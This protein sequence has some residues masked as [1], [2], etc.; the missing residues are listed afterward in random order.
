MACSVES[1]LQL[2]FGFMPKCEPVSLAAEGTMSYDQK[3]NMTYRDEPIED[4]FVHATKSQINY[5]QILATD[6]E[7]NGTTRD[8]LIADTIKRP[9]K[10]IDGLLSKGEA[11]NVIQKFKEIKESRNR[12]EARRPDP[13]ELQSR[14]RGSLHRRTSFDD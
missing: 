9:F 7:L 10:W 11:S 3:K 14:P 1:R 13:N 12:N 6:L 4:T 8:A 5:I 2:C